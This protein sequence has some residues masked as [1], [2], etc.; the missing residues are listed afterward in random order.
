[1]KQ[2]TKK[3]LIEPNVLKSTYNYNNNGDRGRYS[4]ANTS[5][6]YLPFSR[7]PEELLRPRIDG[8]VQTELPDPRAG[9]TD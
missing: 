8:S 9:R 7:Q 3:L 2:H 5:L 6:P 1:M 4:S